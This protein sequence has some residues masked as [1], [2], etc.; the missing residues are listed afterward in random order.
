MDLYYITFYELPHFITIA[1]ICKKLHAP[2]LIAVA[3]I[4]N[5]TK[6]HYF[7]IILTPFFFLKLF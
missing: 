6:L 7:V 2:L 4:C 1:Q 5:N 3:L